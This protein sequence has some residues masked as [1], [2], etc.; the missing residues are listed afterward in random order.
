MTV[1]ATFIPHELIPDDPEELAENM[2]QFEKAGPE[3]VA[4]MKAL[5]HFDEEHPYDYLSIA[6]DLLVPQ[7]ANIAVRDEPD[8]DVDLDIK[9][10]YDQY[11]GRYVA[12]SIHFVRREVGAGVGS[13]AIRAVPIQEYLRAL[14]GT[15]YYSG[16]GFRPVM[17]MPEVLPDELVAQ[18]KRDGPSDDE[19]LRWVARIYIVAEAF[20]LPPGQAVREQLQMPTPT[21]SV[22]IRRARDRGILHRWP[23]PPIEENGP[24]ALRHDRTKL[25][26]WQ[27]EA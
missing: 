24:W 26:G 13:V 21:A 9:V 1:S 8:I 22:W 17:Q 6:P 19:S 12:D 11:A 7:Y 5:M 4:A 23:N 16:Y 2:R 14:T 10:T 15:V 3:N 27:W 18:I 25:G 20:N